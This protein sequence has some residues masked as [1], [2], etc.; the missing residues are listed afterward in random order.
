M[1]QPDR[2]RVMAGE[3]L[4]DDVA[5]S[6]HMVPVV[7][8]GG[9]AVRFAVTIAALLHDQLALTGSPFLPPFGGDAARLH[10]IC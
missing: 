10:S 3:G 1:A 2:H 5:A 9:T 4:S 8:S 7:G 6:E